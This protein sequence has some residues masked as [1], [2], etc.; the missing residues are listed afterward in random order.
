MSTGAPPVL[1][2]KTKNL[3]AIRDAKFTVVFLEKFVEMLKS[4]PSLENMKNSPVYLTGDAIMSWRIAD[5][6]PSSRGL[7]GRFLGAAKSVTGTPLLMFGFNDRPLPYRKRPLLITTSGIF[8]EL[9]DSGV[10]HFSWQELDFVAPADLAADDS[11]FGSERD[12]GVVRQCVKRGRF[13]LMALGLCFLL[14]VGLF[15][16]SYI[17]YSWYN[18][19]ALSAILAILGILSIPL[20]PL[21]FLLIRWGLVIAVRLDIKNR[22]DLDPTAENILRISYIERVDIGV[23]LAADNIILMLKLGLTIYRAQREKYGN[24]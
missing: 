18:N 17:S 9:L 12:K 7:V 2:I 10:R 11:F 6:A 1:D 21:L 22:L 13:N 15:V 16:F 5:V 23:N 24:I 14:V 19:G 4:Q 8:C 20:S 3:I